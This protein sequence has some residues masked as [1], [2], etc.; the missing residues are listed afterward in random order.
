MKA[1]STG[2]TRLS[3]GTLETFGAV[4]GNLY[5]HDQIV[6]RNS[7]NVRGNI[8]APRVA[9]EDGSRFKGSIDMEP[10][11]DKQKPASAPAE[12]KAMPKSEAGSEAKAATPYRPEP[13]TTRA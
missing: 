12:T 11:A 8:T 2:T 9:L 3:S 5:G 1:I 10:R 6:V 13:S 4:E 7:G